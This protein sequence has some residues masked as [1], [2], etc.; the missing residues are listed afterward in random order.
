MSLFP[1]APV[2]D[3]GHKWADILH[4]ASLLSTIKS[5]CIQVL[6]CTCVFV[7]TG[8]LLFFN[9]YGC[10]FLYGNNVIILAISNKTHLCFIFNFHVF[11]L[12][13]FQDSVSLSSLGCCGT[14]S[15][16][17]RSPT[18]KDPPVSAT[19]VWPPLPKGV[20]FHRLR[21]PDWHN[22]CLNVLT[23]INIVILYL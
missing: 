13:F 22:C 3:K 15:L 11:I 20:I 23:Y 6:F 16:Y 8:E 4:I 19:W 5:S 18:H 7:S 21:T 14:L 17:I 2:C 12:N 1:L 10:V 9:I